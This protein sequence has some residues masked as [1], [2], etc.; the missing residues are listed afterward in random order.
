[1]RDRFPLWLRLAVRSL[2]RRPGFSLLAIL[3]L[4]LGIGAN[5]TVFSIM[6]AI[7]LRSLP[8]EDPERLVDVTLTIPPG[9]EEPARHDMVW[10]YPKYQT[11]SALQHSFSA[12]ALYGSSAGTLHLE[13]TALRLTTENISA[14]YFPT[15]G[16]EPSLGRHFDASE[17][18]GPDAPAVA[19]LS[20]PLWRSH[21]GGDP[22]VIGQR[23]RFEGTTV[24]VVGVG[25]PGFRGLT[26][27]ADLWR[28][29]AS[30]GAEELR[31]PW[32]HSHNMVARLSP[33]VTFAQ[34]RARVERLGVQVNA[35]H[36]PPAGSNAMGATAR[37]LAEIRTDP[38]LA[39]TVVVL[40]VAV[41]LVLLIACVNLANLLLARALGRQRELAVCLAVGARRS[42]IVGTLLAESALLGLAGGILGLALTWLGVRGLGSLWTGMEGAIGGRLGGLTAMGLGGIT[43]S[44]T[45]MGFLVGASALTA[46]LV[47]LL[48]A[49]RASG[50]HLTAALRGSA[51]SVTMGGTRIT[52]RDGLVT[53]QLALAVTLLIGAGLMI[54]S[55]A[56]LLATDA[57]VESDGVASARIA[58]SADGYQPDSAVAFYAQLLE[59]VRA[60]PG[61]SAAALGNCPPLSGGCNRTNI[62]FRDRPGV[63]PGQEPLVGVHM[64]SPGWFGTL[65]VRLIRGRD[66]TEADRRGGPKVAILN[67]TAARAFYPAED[68]IG[69]PIAVGQGGF[70]VGSAEI[71]GIVSDVRFQTLENA[72]LR[73][74]FI[75]Y[76]QAPRSAAMLY[77]RTPGN[78]NQL[79]GPLRA[80][81]RELDPS[82][83]VY[84]VRTL[85]DRMALATFRPRYTT[86]VL[87]AFAAAALALAAV[88]IYALLAYE[89]AQR[90]REI[91]IRM[92]L[93]AGSARVIRGVMSRGLLLAGVG[94]LLGIPL[95]IGLSRF[96]AALLFG[97]T[98]NDPATYAAI[99]LTLGGAALAATLLPA[100]AAARVNPM[101]AIR[102]E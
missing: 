31:Y 22:A 46:I 49:W 82:L 3:I 71:V 34:A 72:P 1:M 48:P 64:V 93:G 6:D 100:R 75:P 102:A 5:G 28:N 78:P 14:A 36:P 2:R 32:S 65:G 39:R 12:I 66:F 50:P 45:V 33:G 96:L 25:P 58:L 57:G 52:L 101:E 35:A 95:A 98:P 37:P 4:A 53:A 43:M 73:D 61:V 76:L 80:L 92:A 60:L 20:H 70:H 97:V 16:I 19:I 77:L 79:L 23:L 47:G 88:G 59:R 27:R 94:I 63:P 26:G 38:A 15:L 24:T 90:R 11:F 55:M 89:V 83:P 69:R 68:P 10:S 40:G 81:L 51:G 41:G 29:I 85:T 74:V 42:H 8:F 9:P 13:A 21:F 17:D 84:D 91:G 7:L 99:I 62:W 30:L 54:R 67:E 86:W 87:G 44:P 56:N 18:R